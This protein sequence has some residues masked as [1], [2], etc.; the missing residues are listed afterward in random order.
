MNFSG[1]TRKLVLLLFCLCGASLLFA[2][3]SISG[4]VR[5]QTTGRAAVGDTVLLLRLENGMQE[6]A[7]TVTGPNG[8]FSMPLR[9]DGA[10]RLVRVMHHG[11]NYDQRLDRN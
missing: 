9:Q 2:D 7:R 1:S 5:N 11:V 3:G 8:K 6:E 10:E 4:T